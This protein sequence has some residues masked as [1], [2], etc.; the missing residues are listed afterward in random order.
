MCVSTCVCV[1]VCNRCTTEHGG[2][3]SPGGR[4]GSSWLPAHPSVEPSTLV[5][6]GLVRSGQVTVTYVKNILH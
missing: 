5:R 1:C 3:V 6:S 2:E 4:H